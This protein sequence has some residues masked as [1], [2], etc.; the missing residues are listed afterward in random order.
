[1]KGEKASSSLLCSGKRSRILALFDGHS[2]IAVLESY[3]VLAVDDLS[4]KV[5]FDVAL[6]SQWP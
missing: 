1:M 3:T 2:A 4:I 5:A 6:C